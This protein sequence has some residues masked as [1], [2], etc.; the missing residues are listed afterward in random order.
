M[1]IELQDVEFGIGFM[2]EMVMGVKGKKETPLFITERIVSLLSQ[3]LQENDVDSR[4]W[5]IIDKSGKCVKITI[6]RSENEAETKKS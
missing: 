1:K 3:Y 5:E 2:N 4:T 6:T